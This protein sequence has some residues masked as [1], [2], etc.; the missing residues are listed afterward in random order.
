LFR[1]KHYSFE[2]D[3]WATGCLLAEVALGEAL[4]NGDSEIEQL[5]KIFKFTGSQILML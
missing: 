3:I 1:K 5:F 2:V 4:F